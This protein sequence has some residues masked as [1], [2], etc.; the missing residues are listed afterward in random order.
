MLN[1]RGAG[2]RWRTCTVVETEE[3]PISVAASVDPRRIRSLK[4][5]LLE[6]F[7]F[8]CLCTSQPSLAPQ[9]A[10]APKFPA[11]TTHFGEANE[12][13]E[14]A[15]RAAPL[16]DRVLLLASPNKTHWWGAMCLS[17]LSRVPTEQAQ[18]RTETERP[19]FAFRPKRDCRTP[20]GDSR[21]RC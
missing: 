11:G 15:A 2:K 18:A 9:F 14:G 12:K 3:A 13:V 5:A 20:V 8:E 7:S 16:A 1:R 17:F 19:F 10:C 4:V 6:S 21:R